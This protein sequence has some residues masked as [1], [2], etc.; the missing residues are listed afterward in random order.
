[1]RFEDADLERRYFSYTL[2]Q[3]LAASKYTPWIAAFL[4]LVSAPFDYVFVGGNELSPAALQCL[5]IRCV[6]VILLVASGF[7]IR[8]ASARA[9]SATLI[10]GWVLSV[11]VI[12]FIAAQA[13]PLGAA[14]YT[15]L[16]GLASLSTASL[17]PV[18]SFWQVRAMNLVLIVPFLS[19]ATIHDAVAGSPETAYFAY[20]ALILAST[21]F[22]GLYSKRSYELALRNDFLRSLDLVVAR[23]RAMTA[24]RAK[25]DFLASVSHELRTPLNAILGNVQL[26]STSSGLSADDRDMVEAARKASGAIISLVDDLL[27]VSSTG[28]E[29]APV[30]RAVRIGAVIDDLEA[31]I[32][33]L[34]VQKALRLE[35]PS[36]DVRA[37]W[38][39]IDAEGL[40][41]ILLNLLGNAVKFSREG[42]VGLRLRLSETRLNFLVFDSGIGMEPGQV[43][44]AFEPL[45]RGSNVATGEFAGTGLGLA[46]VDRLVNERG[47]SVRMRSCPGRGTIVSGWLPAT[48]APPAKGAVQV[49]T[50]P[51]TPMRILVI[52]D[53]P[54]NRAV[55]KRMLVRAGHSVLEAETGAQA[56]EVFESGAPD[57]VL[58]DIRLPDTDGVELLKQLT[59][60]SQSRPFDHVPFYAVT[61]NAL[62][63]DLVRYEEAGFDG[64]ISKPY[65][66]RILSEILAEIALQKRLVGALTV[67]RPATQD[68]SG[69]PAESDKLYLQSMDE[70]LDRLRKARAEGNAGTI[71]DVAHR[72]LGTAMTCGDLVTADWARQVDENG[73]AE[74]WSQTHVLDGFEAHLS[75]ITDCGIRKC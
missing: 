70:C 45:F 60:L 17:V 37:N 3:S 36:R 62:P 1:V 13:A 63:E 59:R 26:L 7:F 49:L 52:E 32:G 28:A 31:I 64:V 6:T 47:G 35:M 46:I 21:I 25:S 22:M 29:R 74:L 10:L 9:K 34:A 27:R 33:V 23:D 44:H 14:F 55:L 66:E 4:F 65:E 71:A 61:A 53:D 40:R 56:V 69:A 68:S 16:L 48:A 38:I 42:R 67:Q 75:R 18:L 12:W 72:V 8:V 30:T 19:L 20:S 51:A 2:D 5:A 54:A 58:S 39:A 50:P 43:R 11:L 41:Q 15:S 24:D 73:G 57:C